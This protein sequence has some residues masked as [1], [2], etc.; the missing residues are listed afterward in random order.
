MMDDFLFTIVNYFVNQ[1]NNQDNYIAELLLGASID[2]EETSQYGQKWN[3]M[4]AGIIIKVPYQIQYYFSEQLK[5]RIIEVCN[6]FV[7]RSWNYEFTYL[8]VEPQLEH[9]YEG[10][11]QDVLTLIRQ[12]NVNNQA[13]FEFTNAPVYTYKGLKFRSR[14]EV[15]VMQEFEKYTDILVFPLPIAVCG[16]NKRE[17][18]FLVLK[19]GKMKIL[20]V[21]SDTYHPSVEDEAARTRWFQLHQLQIIAYDAHRCYEHTEEVVAEFLHLLNQ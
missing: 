7:P 5:E 3:F 18:D 12:Q 4:Q 19:N 6:R 13:S 10:W 15:K 16:G 1:Q 9:E 17:P 20:E 14:T 21:V 8:E 2:I 11:Q